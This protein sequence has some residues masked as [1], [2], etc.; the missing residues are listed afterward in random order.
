MSKRRVTL[1]FASRYQ[2]L[3]LPK[4]KGSSSSDLGNCSGSENMI[5]E[6]SIT[7]PQIKMEGAKMSSKGKIIK[8]F[9]VN[10]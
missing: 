3:Q 8:H 10:T 5:R 1:T 4:R 6:V 7:F 9:S 2:I